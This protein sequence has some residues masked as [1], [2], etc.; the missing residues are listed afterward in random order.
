MDAQE[1]FLQRWESERPIYAAWGKHVEEQISYQVKNKLEIE[2]VD[3]FFRVPVKPR[4]KDSDSLLSKAFYRGKGYN[5]PYSD[6]E[7]KVG[8]RF[9]VLTSEDIQIVSESLEAH[10]DWGFHKA[11][12][13]LKEIESD[14]YYF[15]YQSIH[16]VVRS[17][18]DIE[19][20]GINVPE[21]TPCEVQIRTIMQH[22]YSEITHD[23]IYKSN[24]RIDTQVRRSVAKS[25]ALIEATD[26][27]FIKTKQRIAELQAGIDKASNELAAIYRD[28]VA[29]EPKITKLNE[30]IISAYI[31]I[32]QDKPSIEEF[33]DAESY[34]CNRIKTNY[35]GNVL[36]RQPAITLVYFAVGNWPREALQKS[37]LTE[38]ELAPIYSDLG[39][40]LPE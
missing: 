6:I 12:D 34:I 3:L 25:M 18:C 11:R 8:V 7:D 38:N 10:K 16:Y 28:K 36:Y 21:G 5:D 39:K 40:R 14:P 2:S 37:P 4:V 26:D 15:D 17:V 22:A 13:Y 31:D 1:S 24:I 29:I 9:V 19:C 20:D 33:I 27:Y 30:I 35:D 32:Y 23:T